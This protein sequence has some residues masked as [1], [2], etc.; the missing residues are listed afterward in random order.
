MDKT[1]DGNFTVY[2]AGT[3]VHC[4][5]C[6]KGFQLTREREGMPLL[7]EQAATRL[8]QFE[9]CPACNAMDT[10]WVYARDYKSQTGNG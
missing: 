7:P 1:T 3:T 10:H 2:P 4:N 6:D 5:R 8:T 9:T